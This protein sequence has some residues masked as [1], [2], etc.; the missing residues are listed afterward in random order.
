MMIFFLSAFVDL[1]RVI[2]SLPRRDVC[3]VRSWGF[4]TAS[5]VWQLVAVFTVVCV[6]QQ[7]CCTLLSLLIYP[8]ICVLSDSDQGL[9]IT[10]N[11]GEER[12]SC[13]SLRVSHPRIEDPC[14][15]SCRKVVWKGPSMVN[16]GRL[17]VCM[18]ILSLFAVVDLG[19]SDLLCLPRGCLFD[20][21]RVF[22][23]ISILWHSVDVFVE[24]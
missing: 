15:R 11:T 8:V 18:I 7:I 5:S 13:C 20:R 2:C 24:A 17:H 23:T 16:S 14:Y 1:V 22:F 3:I 9:Y 4:S 6:G 21:Y 12:R 19:R 10:T